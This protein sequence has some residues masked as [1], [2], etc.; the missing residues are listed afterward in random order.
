MLPHLTFPSSVKLH[1]R[2]ESKVHNISYAVIARLVR[3]IQ[4]GV[5]RWV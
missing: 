4:S 2:V 3:A 5:S 1:L